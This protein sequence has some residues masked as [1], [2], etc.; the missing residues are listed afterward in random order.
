MG[1]DRITVGRIAAALFICIVAL[2]AAPSSAAT[3]DKVPITT[4]V[5]PRD[6]E[7]IRGAFGTLRS[8]RFF[9]VFS[10]PSESSP[11]VLAICGTVKAQTLDGTYDKGVIFYGLLG[12]FDGK[13]RSFLRLLE[14]PKLAAEQCRANGYLHAPPV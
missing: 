11:D 3:I 5:E 13:Q 4:F 14:D 7:I 2:S 8:P 1:A 10:A 9:D 6:M 12:P